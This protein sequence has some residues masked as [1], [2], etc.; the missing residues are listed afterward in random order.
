M[1]LKRAGPWFLDQGEKF[2]PVQI[3]WKIHTRANK[4]PSGH[5]FVLFFSKTLVE[6]SLQLYLFE[7]HKRLHDCQPFTS[8]RAPY[9]FEQ[10]E[11]NDPGLIGIN[12]A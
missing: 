1:G 10:T 6:P 5:F 11:K 3:R 7:L 2:T 4:C 8:W 12:G 9:S